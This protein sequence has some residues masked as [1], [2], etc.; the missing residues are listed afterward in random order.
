MEDWDEDWD[1]FWE[2]F[3]D[4]VP[5]LF[6]DQVYGC[7]DAPW[8]GFYDFFGEAC[9]LD[10]TDRLKPLMDL[11]ECCGWWAPYKNVCF[12]QHRPE[13]IA[14]VDGRLHCEDGP[15]IRYRDGFSVWAIDGVRCDEQI[16]MQPGTQTI[17]QISKEQNEEIKRI[18]IDRFGWIKYLNGIGAVR[19][20]D[21][22]NDIEGTREY[23]YCAEETTVLLCVC[24][25][26]SKTFV[27]EVPQEVKT[28]EQAQSYLSSGLSSRI[29]SAS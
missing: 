16:V 29:I 24:P 13:K 3:K 2:Y 14:I 7:H 19:I 18:R 10:C 25:S 17:E 4:R 15:A 28:C 1:E 27:L 8:L 26:T 9:G 12:L 11:A 21:R 6:Q 5:K 22:R 20:D 23:L